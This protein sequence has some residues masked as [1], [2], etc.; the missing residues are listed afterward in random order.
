MNFGQRMLVEDL[1]GSLLKVFFY[2]DDKPFEPGETVE[3][4]G[5]KAIVLEN[6]GQCGIVKEFRRNCKFVWF[7]K[8]QGEEVKRAQN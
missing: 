4:C 6:L 3:F 5:D 7:W 1:I 8:F 2:N